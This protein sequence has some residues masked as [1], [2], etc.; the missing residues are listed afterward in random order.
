MGPALGEETEKEIMVSRKHGGVACVNNVFVCTPLHA[1]VM[2]GH[3][4]VAP[5]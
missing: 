4:Q 5:L 2:Q 1:V 3:H